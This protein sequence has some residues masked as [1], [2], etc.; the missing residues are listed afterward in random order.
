MPGASVTAGGG[1]RSCGGGRR[2]AGQDCVELSWSWRCPGLVMGH[3]NR[4]PSLNRSP[5]R[6]GRLLDG[7]GSSGT[8]SVG[9]G[10]HTRCR[11]IQPAWRPITDGVP[12]DG[13]KLGGGFGGGWGCRSTHGG[14]LRWAHCGWLFRAV[15]KPMALSTGQRGAMHDRVGWRRSGRGGRRQRRGGRYGRGVRIWPIVRG[16]SGEGGAT[17]RGSWDGTAMDGGGSQGGEAAAG[18]TR[19]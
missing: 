8:T 18:S 5:T 15:R 3:T 1:A 7:E 19:P 11:T 14:S 6:R 12:R 2:R 13:V 10:R 4:L 16:G 17:P 9:A